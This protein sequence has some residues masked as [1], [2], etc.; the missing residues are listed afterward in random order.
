MPV[1]YAHIHKN[2]DQFA[3]LTRK[4]L[5]EAQQNLK[6]ATEQIEQASR[7]QEAVREAV[8]RVERQASSLHTAMPGNEAILDT[9]P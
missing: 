5:E 2:L 3:D 1:N 7:E 9:F 4:K 8:A 6:N